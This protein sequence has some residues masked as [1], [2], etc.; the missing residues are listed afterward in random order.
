METL[1]A[2][3]LHSK[4]H[5]FAMICS[6]G[7]DRVDEFFYELRFIPKIETIILVVDMQSS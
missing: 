1:N 5:R 6:G 7:D 2:R 3:P 4:D